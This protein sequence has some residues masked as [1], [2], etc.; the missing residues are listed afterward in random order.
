[1]DNAYGKPATLF[2]IF[3]FSSLITESRCLQWSNLQW[4]EVKIIH[5]IIC[6]IA[7]GM[8]SRKVWKYIFQSRYIQHCCIL[9]RQ[10]KHDW[11]RHIYAKYCGWQFVLDISQNGRSM[12]Y[13]IEGISESLDLH[14]SSCET[15][16]FLQTS[17]FT[18]CSPS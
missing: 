5:S 7:F 6:W 9:K 14:S 16:W 1:M 13:S 4:I 12:W 15:V 3:P 8:E 11:P 17:P 2:S 10:D 18:T